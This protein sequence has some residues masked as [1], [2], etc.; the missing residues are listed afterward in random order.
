MA[1]PILEAVA[2]KVEVQKVISEIA[3]AVFKSA[4]V[5]LDSAA[6]AVIPSVP[7]M[8][9]DVLEDLK[10]GSVQKFNLAMDKLD[11]LVRTLGIDLKNYSKELA[12]FADKTR[13]KA[14]YVRSKNTGIKRK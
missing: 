5:S 2:D 10:S 7:D 11:K 12:N 6:K 4:K 13:R 1:L 3:T 9:D 14:N 8:V